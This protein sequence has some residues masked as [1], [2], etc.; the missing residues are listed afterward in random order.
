MYAIA[1]LLRL[2]F[3]NFSVFGADV[4]P[5]TAFLYGER[6]LRGAGTGHPGAIYSSETNGADTKVNMVER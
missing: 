6:Y 3:S 1:R 2:G 4:S 5:E